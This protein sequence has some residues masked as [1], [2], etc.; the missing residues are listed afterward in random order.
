[1]ENT[2]KFYSRRDFLKTLSA[3]AL[4]LGVGRNAFGDDKDNIH[5]FLEERL[6]ESTV[7]TGLEGGRI[8]QDIPSVFVS[9]E[10]DDFS[11]GNK[12]RQVSVYFHFKNHHLTLA[13]SFHNPY[14]QTRQDQDSSLFH[15]HSFFDT[16]LGNPSPILKW[17]HCLLS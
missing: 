16:F 14:I 17:C 9:S 4:A 15:W 2:K 7:R 5:D 13:R 11:N 1:M 12:Q 10:D 6:K 3:G 8:Y